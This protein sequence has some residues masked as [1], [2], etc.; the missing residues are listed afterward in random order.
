MAIFHGGSI[1]TGRRRGIPDELEGFASITW[2]GAHD[3]GTGHDRDIY[4]STDFARD[5]QGGQFEVYFC[6]TACLRAFFNS[7][8]DVLETKIQK[9]KQRNAKARI[10]A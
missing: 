2:H 1:Y 6:S 10:T 3:M 5:C 7:W 4:T 8:V 9:E